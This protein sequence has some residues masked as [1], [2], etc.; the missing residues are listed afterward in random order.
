[1]SM[2]PDT[3]ETPITISK[4]D[5]VKNGLNKTI[6]EYY[7]DPLY[8]L[9]YGALPLLIVLLFCG[10]KISFEVYLLLGLFGLSAI[11]K[12]IKFIIKKYL[13]RGKSKS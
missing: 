7:N 6:K 5:K 2:H 10:V 3:F 9:F 8:Y 13:W 1:M 11:R 4:F 12:Q